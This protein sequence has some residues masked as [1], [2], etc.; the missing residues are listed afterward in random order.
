[1]VPA[2]GPQPGMPAAGGYTAPAPAVPSAPMGQAYNPNAPVQAV[3]AP[4]LPQSMKCNSCGGPLKPSAGLALVVCEYCGAVTT[5]GA[6]GVAQVFQKHFMLDSRI[7]NEQALEAGG[8]WLNKGILRRKVAERS[9]LGTVT[10]K[11]VPYWVVPTSVVADFQGTKNVG[12]G[13]GGGMMVH[14]DTGA[15]KAAGAALFALTMAAAAA[16]SRNQ[17]QHQV[18]QGPQVIR[19]RD[20]IQMQYNIPIVAVRGYA[21]YQPDDGFQFQLQ[22]KLNFDKRQTGG[23]D[24]MGGDVAEGEAKTQ[25]QALAHK[26]AE[27]EAKKRVDTLES[28]Q[29]YPTTYDGELLHAPV[30]FMEY[31][32]KGKPFFILID[33]HTGTVMDGE[34]PT[35][36][37]W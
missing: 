12:A 24:V 7:S 10:L 25:A 19:V 35:F 9:E 1:V 30:W 2:Q 31:Q 8:K 14:G 23:L 29:V 34:R 37:L 5:M 6:G 11:Y 32:H 33:G 3:A 18:A 13:A 22:N 15:K 36:A 27:R 20:R 16:G 4:P 26:F 17:P 21:K 28:I